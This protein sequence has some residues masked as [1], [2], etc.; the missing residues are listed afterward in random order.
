M[1]TN[2]DIQLHSNCKPN[3][4]YNYAADGKS[5]TSVT[6]STTGNTCAVNVPVTFPGTATPTVA[7]GV[8]DKVGTEPLIYWT[9]MKGSAVTY[10]LGSAVAI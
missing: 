10:N 9:P 3:L 5:I 2:T 4:S 1:Q 7:G 8:S 6:V